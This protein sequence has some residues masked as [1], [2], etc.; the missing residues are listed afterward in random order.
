MVALDTFIVYVIWSASC[1]V[2]Y[3]PICTRKFPRGRFYILKY[4]GNHPS[5]VFYNVLDQFMFNFRL[6][7]YQL[8]RKESSSACLPAY[9]RQLH[10]LTFPEIFVSFTFIS[11]YYVKINDENRAICASYVNPP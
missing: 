4:V 8:Q 11:V 1:S 6:C 7:P 9:N 5:Y 10:R 3:F 2:V